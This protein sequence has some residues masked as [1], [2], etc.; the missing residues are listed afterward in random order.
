VPAPSTTGLTPVMPPLLK[1]YL[2][3]GAWV[4]GEPCW[5]PEFRVAD[6][7]V[8]LDVTRLDTRYARHFLRRPDLLAP[9][10]AVAS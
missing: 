5:D 10:Y 8:L 7:F 1:A 6:V 3:L 2:R 9:D 4:C